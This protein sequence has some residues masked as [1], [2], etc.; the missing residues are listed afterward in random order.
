MLDVIYDSLPYSA[1]P[2]YDADDDTQYYTITDINNSEL[3]QI[4][5][6]NRILVPLFG[7]EVS[8]EFKVKPS[9]LEKLSN[10]Y[11]GKNNILEYSELFSNHWCK[12]INKEKIA[13]V[14]IIK[15]FEETGCNELNIIS[16]N[17]C[18]TAFP[19]K[20]GIKFCWERKIGFLG[21]KI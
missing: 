14:N 21:S 8:R 6:R 18:T 19:I 1:L 4:K 20:N 3:I 5:N 7:Q 2:M 12:E 11:I 10:F 16:S 9:F 13:P 15:L 17:E